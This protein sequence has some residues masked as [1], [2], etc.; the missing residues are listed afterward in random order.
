[1]GSWLY[2]LKN[3]AGVADTA[4]VG[5]GGMEVAVDVSIGDAVSAGVQAARRSIKPINSKLFFLII[6][7]IK[8]ARL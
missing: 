6:T 2:T 5:V 8:S 7:P 4:R 1:M 3:G